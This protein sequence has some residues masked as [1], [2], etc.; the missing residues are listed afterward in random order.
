MTLSPHRLDHAQCSERIDEAG[1][2]FGRLRPGGQRQTLR[3][4]ERAVLRIHR[5]A[6]HGDGL[7]KQRL[8]RVRGACLNHQAGAFI[9]DWHGFIDARRHRT[10]QLLR[11]R[12]ADD[13]IGA[14]A[15]H[16]RGTHVRG[17]EHQ[18]EIGWIDRRGFDAHDDFVGR[19]RRDWNT[20]QRDFEL[21]ALSDERAKLQTGLI[22]AHPPQLDAAVY[23]AHGRYRKFRSTARRS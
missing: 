7:A 16:F 12:R 6:E 14:G 17:A 23:A 8:R 22:H 2:A 15:A 5:A 1:R 9:A 4:L 18:A 19:G 20:A 11:N 21:A 10:H 13:R 3:D